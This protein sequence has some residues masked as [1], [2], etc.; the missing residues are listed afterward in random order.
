MKQFIL[1]L[2]LGGMWALMPAQQWLWAKQFGSAT[3]GTDS[4]DKESVTAMETDKDGN[5]YIAGG[6]LG[7]AKWEGVPVPAVGNE[8]RGFVAKYDCDGNLI[9]RNFVG[10][11]KGELIHSITHDEDG[12][13]YF[14]ARIWTSWPTI[15]YTH[16]N[17]SLVYFSTSPGGTVLGKINPSGKLEW[18][19]SNDWNTSGPLWESYN[20]MKV[21][22]QKLYVV[23]AVGEGKSPF[24]GFPPA[25][26]DVRGDV[27]VCFDVNGTPLWS[28]V[29]AQGDVQGQFPLI[30]EEGNIY[31][32]G[33][34]R[35]TVIIGQTMLIGSTP[36]AGYVAKYD[37]MGNHLWVRYMIPSNSSSIQGGFKNIINEGNNYYIVFGVNSGIEFQSGYIF[38]FY[39][40]MP[41]SV[42]SGIIKTDKDFTNIDWMI[43]E[44]SLMFSGLQG[45]ST[46]ICV[47]PEKR[48]M[49]DI[50]K[51]T[52]FGGQK[53]VNNCNTWAQTPYVVRF[54]SNGVVSPNPLVIGNTT[55]GWIS[56]VTGYMGSNEKGDIYLA[57]ELK[58]NLIFGNDTLQNANF[59]GNYAW[60]G[61]LTKYGY[62]CSDSN[63]MVPPFAAQEL[64]ASATGSQS[65]AVTWNDVSNIESGYKLYRSPNGVSNWLPVATLPQNTENYTDNAVNPNTLYYY[66]TA[67]YN[68]QGEVFSNAD[69]A[70]TLTTA[71]IPSFEGA[72]SIY[73]NPNNGAFSLEITAKNP[74]NGQ[75]MIADIIGKTVYQQPIHMPAGS[76][77]IGFVL[78]QLPQGYYTFTLR[79]EKGETWTEKVVIE[80]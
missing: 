62:E 59:G 36:T 38:N 76:S 29:I 15:T 42:S 21:R 52:V 25:V 37:S 68:N 23:M 3:P 33:G 51:T 41:S 30:D 32:V 2:I 35:D 64:I 74:V 39:R 49:G 63:A 45:S 17:D 28:K 57:G 9:W 4:G 67:A 43:Y 50:F 48:F 10:S 56:G 12:N 78:L 6:L 58:D 53:F 18:M 65:I 40:V 69:S 75:I 44:D 47:Y 60:D 71:L 73:P 72:A 5:I 16:F 34:Y 20:S 46:D 24:P 26:V 79:T 61:F 1:M 55:A 27:L 66:K 22:N 31:T 14:I 19:K 7:N 11:N 13:C 54:D 80:K 8:R 77:Q 70:K